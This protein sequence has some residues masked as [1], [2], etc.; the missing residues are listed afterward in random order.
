[1]WGSQTSIL[2]SEVNECKDIMI[3][4]QRYPITSVLCTLTH[5][6]KVGPG[7]LQCLLFLL[8]LLPLPCLPYSSSVVYVC[9]WL[10]M[11]SVLHCTLLQHVLCSQT[12]WR[13]KLRSHR[14]RLSSLSMCVEY[15]L[16]EYFVIYNDLCHVCLNHTCL[17][18]LWHVCFILTPKSCSCVC[19]RMWIFHSWWVSDSC[20]ILLP[21][22]YQTSQTG[23]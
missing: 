18:L 8:Y 21:E 3:I 22:G 5:P 14:S 15:K 9:E 4:K 2:T 11:S 12:E 7:V 1:M 23:H 16:G 17:A 19:V 6:M 13:V 10:G 20:L